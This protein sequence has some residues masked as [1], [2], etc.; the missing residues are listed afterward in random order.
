MNTIHNLP[1]SI[2]Q[3]AQRF[4]AKVAFR[5]LREEVSYGELAQQVQQL[6]SVLRQSGVKKGD[7][8]GIF[9]ARSLE[10]A[11][12]MYGIMAAGA[13]YVPIN[14]QQPN[15]RINFILAEC[16]IKIL[17]TNA[18][19]RRRLRPLFKIQNS[20][21]L[22]IGSP[23]ELP[24]ATLTWAEVYTQEIDSIDIPIL[25][26]DPAYILY[27]SGSTGTPKGI[28]HTHRSGLAYAKLA[29][30]TYDLTE[31]DVIGNHAPIYFD[32]STLGYFAASLVGA[33]TII[34]S[35]AHVKM[36]VSLAEL[37]EKENITV[38]YSVPLALRQ[39]LERGKLAER[40][41][42]ALRLVIFAGELFP[43]K[44][45]RATMQTLPQATFCNAYGPTETNVC[46]NFFLHSPP[47]YDRPISIGQTWNNTEILILNDEDEVVN[48]SEKGELLVRSS[49]LMQGYWNRPDLN[50]KVF[51]F[52]KMNDSCVAKFY[53]TGDL[54]SL[55]ADGNLTFY[56]RKDRQIKTRGYR[57][58]LDEITNTLLQ[59]EAIAEAAVYTILDA[60]G[61]NSLAASVL[62]KKGT[63]L[64][65]QEIMQFL[66]QKLLWYAV[67]QQ[68]RIVEQLPRTAT[69][70]I[71]LKQLQ[72]HNS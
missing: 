6:A 11:V 47:K 60:E 23:I 71:D 39:M 21:T 36:P 17:L 5:C 10:T 57:V 20:L 33:S 66:K 44:H 61:E 69:G 63:T 14:P 51:L 45:L 9:M 65:Q 42:P 43:T 28:L 22:V 62:L 15:E 7:C 4:P 12:A 29:I 49:T 72:V 26:D 27:T 40:K 58:E 16:Q 1:Q 34:A 68:V 13:I 46:T 53:R 59:H 18:G 8:V 3:A 41:L 37:L 64:E 70:K 2:Q 35:E 50:E 25:E 55:Q 48:N 31:K 38:W 19:Q 54:V 30:E 32:I 24:V 52:K 56:G 67:P